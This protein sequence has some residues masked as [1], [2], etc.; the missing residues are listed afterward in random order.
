MADLPEERLEYGNPAFYH[1]GVDYFGPFL[2][3]QGRARAKRYGCLFTCM[4]I[5]AVHLEVAHTMEADSF[6]QC[7]LRFIAR[8][9]VPNTVRSDNGTNF[10]GAQKALSKELADLGITWKFNPPGASHAGGVWERQ[11]RTVRRLLTGLMS[12][13]VL[14]DEA[15]QTLFCRV[16]SLIN[17]RPLTTVST[18]PNDLNALTPNH[19]LIL[20]SSGGHEGGFDAPCL[21]TKW[22]QVE[23]LSQLF[24]S[25]WLKEYIPQQ[26]A[27]TKWKV[28]RRNLKVGDVVVVQD[29]TMPRGQ[30]LL[31]RIFETHTDKD[32]L[33]RQVGVMTKKGKQLRP[34]SRLCLL[35]GSP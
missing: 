27:R 7:L 17:G 23:Y 11:I 9:G 3:K 30:W 24:W 33:V 12:E 14:T 22:R 20:G 4:A 18:D 19:L 32:G 5:R 6:L 31:G 29:K 28:A 25:R 15:L 16:E 35:E 26:Q 13:Q 21:R 1:C 10:V 34:I 8:R 2:V